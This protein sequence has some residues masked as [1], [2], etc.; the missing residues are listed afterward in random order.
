MACQPVVEALP[1]EVV[2]GRKQLKNK[3]F[4]FSAGAR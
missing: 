1:I 2:D 4:Q 3:Y